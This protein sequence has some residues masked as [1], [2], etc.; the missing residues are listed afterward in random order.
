MRKIRTIVIHETDGTGDSPRALYNSLKAK[1]YGIHFSVQRSGRIVRHHP[2]DAA[3]V[4]AGPFNDESIGVEAHWRHGE[5]VPG[6]A[7]IAAFWTARI[8]TGKSGVPPLAQLESIWKLCTIACAELGIPVRFPGN[9]GGPNPRVD[10]YTMD[11]PE[12]MPRNTRTDP[13]AEAGI[14]AHGRWGSHTDGRFQEAYCWF[15][16]QGHSP[17]AA[18]QKAVGC[19]S[20]RGLR[21]HAAPPIITDMEGV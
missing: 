4:H 6:Q 13:D 21:M 18:V 19:S 7:P 5:T 11:R 17:S 1:G 9:P 2:L 20:K 16:A 14:V 15:R 3:V 8:P 10:W 12:Q